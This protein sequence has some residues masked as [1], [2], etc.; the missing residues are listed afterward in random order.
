MP[1][2][3]FYRQFLRISYNCH[4]CAP[5][6]DWGGATVPP[7]C[8]PLGDRRIVAPSQRGFDVT[9]A[10]SFWMVGSIYVAVVALILLENDY[11]WR[12][13][14]VMCAAPSILG[15]TLVSMLVPES[16]RFLALQ[17]HY[18]QALYTINHLALKME[19]QGELLTLPQL[20]SQFPRQA[21][22][23]QQQQQ[24]HTLSS[25]SSSTLTTWPCLETS[26]TRVTHSFFDTPFTNITNHDHSSSIGMVQSFPLDPMVFSRGSIPCLWPSSW[27]MSILML[28]CL[29]RRICQ[30]MSL[31]LYVWIAS[32]E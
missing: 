27:K 25:S 14:A 12:I 13:F 22:Q 21:H 3:G 8:L 19:Y 24:V 1:W 23:Q 9:L 7:T 2:R 20:V 28:Y 4:Y 17:G 31:R 10:A 11:S 6:R 16:P 5:W 32:V 15:A 26:S 29:R 30:A 18:E